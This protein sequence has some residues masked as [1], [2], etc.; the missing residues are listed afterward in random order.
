MRATP[1]RQAPGVQNGRVQKKNNWDVVARLLFAP[2]TRIGD[3]PSASGR[4]LSPRFDCSAMSSDSSPF[5]PIGTRWR[6]AWT[7]LFWRRDAKIIGG[8]HSPGVVHVCAWTL[9]W[10]RFFYGEYF[11]RDRVSLERIGVPLSIREG[12]AWA[13]F[14]PSTA[15]AFLLT[16]VLLR[17][18]GHHHDAMTTK[19]K[20][21]SRGEPY[22]NASVIKYGALVWERFTKNFPLD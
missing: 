16:D 8:W 17:E 22:A 5:C 7:R 4:G 1:R 10:G 11:E 3:R 13:Q 15:R 2:A 19:S 12:G 14:T 9:E 21:R 20:R 18:L 6:A